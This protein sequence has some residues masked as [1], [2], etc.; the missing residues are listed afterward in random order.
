[1]KTVLIN[2][3]IAA[4]ETYI[5]NFEYGLPYADGPAYYQDKQ[6]IRELRAELDVWREILELVTKG[7]V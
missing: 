4:C 6:R 5:R 7:A 3:Q 2:R 1:M